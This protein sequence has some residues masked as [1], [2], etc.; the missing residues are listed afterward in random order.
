MAFFCPVSPSQKYSIFGLRFLSDARRNIEVG[1]RAMNS[2]EEGRPP[3]TTT[4]L[5]WFSPL[6]TVPGSTSNGGDANSTKPYS[7]PGPSNDGSTCDS[8]VSGHGSVDQ[9]RRKIR[10]RL[11]PWPSASS[12]RMCQPHDDSVK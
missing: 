6:R 11:W 12:H 5:I 2:I 9:R 1:I 3:C 7:G 4:H 10:V 8:S